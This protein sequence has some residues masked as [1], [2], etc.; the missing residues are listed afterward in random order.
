[1]GPA[2]V[3][4]WVQ[5][6]TMIAPLCRSPFIAPALLTAFILKKAHPMAQQL[7]PGDGEAQ[8][9][10]KTHTGKD[11]SAWRELQKAKD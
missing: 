4:P 5:Q 9:E 10:Q 3:D 8:I 2:T 7:P 1:M 11:S 6:V